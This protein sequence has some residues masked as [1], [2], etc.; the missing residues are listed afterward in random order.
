MDI[1]PEKLYGFGLAT[2]AAIER[3]YR[4]AQ[5]ALPDRRLV[6]PGL[7]A[8]DCELLGV[9]IER[10]YPF[11]GSVAQELIADEDGGVAF[12]MRAAT[13]VV[14]MLRCVPVVTRSGSPPA[15]K[16]EEKAAEAILRDP[17]HLWR[18]LIEAQAAGT[19]P[20]CGGLG[21]ESWESINP[22]GGLGGGLLRFRVALI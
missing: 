18:S 22:D 6:V 14:Y 13:V 3:H 9:H 12:M 15:A 21:W 19:L 2:V 17:V 5:I 20:G 11:D 4:S 10:V 7:P 8:Y 16:D 1:D